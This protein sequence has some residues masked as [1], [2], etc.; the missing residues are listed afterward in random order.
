MLMKKTTEF[1]CLISLVFSVVLV[2]TTQAQDNWITHREDVRMIQKYLKKEG[3]D[4]GRIDGLSGPRTK[5]AIMAYQAEKE[6]PAHGKIT[7]E[8]VTRIL[9]HVKVPE[10]F[11]IS[12]S[13]GPAH[14]DWGGV[15]EVSVKANGN[16]LV[17]RQKGLRAD[18]TRETLA[19]GQLTPARM[20]MMYTQ[21]MSCG[22][23]RLKK[24]YSNPRIIDGTVKCLRITA[25][26]KSHSVSS[27]NK[28]ESGIYCSALLLKAAIPSAKKHIR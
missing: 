27:S 17:T 7:E 11:F 28:Y 15:I 12:Y 22:I 18:G 2:T 6:L 5:G 3:Y 16:Y 9:S 10:D 20:K 26:G 24:H 23:F 8:L 1:F 25:H 21:A 19:E 14:R 13:S 4:P